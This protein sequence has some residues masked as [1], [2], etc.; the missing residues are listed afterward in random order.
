MKKLS[1]FLIFTL[2]SYIF[3]TSANLDLKSDQVILSG[4]NIAFIIILT[5]SAATTTS[6]LTGNLVSTSDPTKTLAFTCTAPSGAKSAATEVDCATSPNEAGTYK[7]SSSGL[8]FTATDG[9]S[10]AV[11]PEL[12]TTTM[13]I[14]LAS[15]NGVPSGITLDLKGSQTIK[16]GTNIELVLTVKPAGKPIL[17]SAISGLELVLSTSDS[18]K[19]SLTCTISSA[20]TCAKDTDTEFKCTAASITAEGT[21]KLGGTLTLTSKQLDGT[22]ISGVTPSIG[23]TTLTVSN[24]SGDDSKPNTSKYLNISFCLFLMLLFF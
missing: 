15:D 13:D 10:N 23:T 22:A 7:L 19:T 8:T 2:I 6:A 9:E 14:F 17:V 16:T 20:T 11:T 12:G 4:S 21:Y 5:P 1:I 3:S 24:S 18:T